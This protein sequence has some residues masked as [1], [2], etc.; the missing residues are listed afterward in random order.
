MMSKIAVVGAGIIGA[1]TAWALSKRGHE[2]YLFEKNTPISHTSRSSSKLLHGGLRYLETGQFSLVKKALLARRFWLENA[3]HLSHPLP[4]MFPIYAKGGRPK[5]QV[6]LGLKLYDYLA[7][8]SGLK[9][10]IWLNQQQTQV[11]NPLLKGIGLIGAYQFYDAQMDDF[12]LGLWVLQQAQ[13]SG[14]QLID[15]HRI[16]DLSELHDFD[17]IVNATG[18]WV[19]ELR[20]Q[21]AG[22]ANHQIDWVRGSHIMVN[23]PYPHALMLP[24]PN[25]KRIFFV[26]PYQ[27]KT[28]IG[29][30]EVRQDSPDAEPPSDS[31]IN[32]LLDAYNHYHQESLSHT[33][34]Y[35]TFSGVRPLLK[36]A[37][38][39]SNAKREWA[40]E[41][42]DNVLHIYGGKWTTAQIQGE[43]AADYL[44]SKK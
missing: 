24:V 20:E 39:P 18:P 42:V 40:F 14:T 8:G 32:Y 25:E 41:K 19:M 9:P 3:P 29:T 22:S 23:M 17:Y 10:S 13:N 38:N 26:L 43:A 44:L 12:A 2:V 31:E 27:N 5:W 33:G 36:T 16:N 7:K 4:L 34:I 1:S 21:Q 11:N 15:N 6:G 35:N 30:T 28:L 37:D